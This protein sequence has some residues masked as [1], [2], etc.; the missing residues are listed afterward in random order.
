MTSESRPTAVIWD[1]D[2]TLVDTRMK[3]IAVTRC[4]VETVSG[5]SA[6]EFSALR[7]LKG[8]G[9]ATARSTNWRDLYRTAFG[10]S[11]EQTDI[12]GRMWTAHQLEDSTPSP[13]FDGIPGVMA[14]LRQ[15]PHGIV[16]QNSSTSI[17]DRLGTMEFWPQV[18]CVVGFEEVDLQRQKPAPD[19]LLA[20]L[21]RLTGLEDA[22]AFYIGDHETDAR[23]AAAANDILRHWGREAHV[24]SIGA[25]YSG[26]HAGPPA[27][28][29]RPDFGVWEPGEIVAIVER[30]AGT[31]G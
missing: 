4:I 2:G 30:V 26:D 18:G 10:F 15:L 25:Y 3:N 5:R 17:T 9:E 20:C 16:S 24:Y 21:E 19:G 29:V 13:V 28:E 1:Y 23:C 14:A 22:C 11:E 27:W 7:D 31:Q 8:Y 12:A 6:D